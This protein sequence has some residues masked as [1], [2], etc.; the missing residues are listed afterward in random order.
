VIHAHPL[1]A[2]AC[3]AAGVRIDAPVIP[4]VV[5]LLGSIPTAEYATPSGDESAMAVREWIG[6]H[7]AIL[8]DRHG[9]VTVGK[10]LT[11]AFRKLE[12]VEYTAQVVFLA[13]Q[14]GELRTLT[15]VQIAKL[16]DVAARLG[17]GTRA[18]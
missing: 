8:L 9:S 2:V 7:D 16:D 4:E 1:T 14:M 17:H 15:P 6:Q 3:T 5:A 10:T 11:E 13:R 18:Y 12:K